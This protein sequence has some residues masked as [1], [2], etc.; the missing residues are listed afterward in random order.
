[1]S[2]TKMNRT[3]YKSNYKTTNS[4]KS[5]KCTAQKGLK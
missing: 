5:K 4:K 2:K 1:M 3:N